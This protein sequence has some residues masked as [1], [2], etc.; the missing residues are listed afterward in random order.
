M[1]PHST[2]NLLIEPYVFDM[3]PHIETLFVSL[4]RKFLAALIIAS[5]P[6][7][8]LKSHLLFLHQCND[9]VSVLV[10]LRL[11]VSGESPGVRSVAVLTSSSRSGCLLL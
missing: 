3:S 1:L 2:A 8:T 5:A 11:S 9:V 6:S 10:K 4:F 7:L